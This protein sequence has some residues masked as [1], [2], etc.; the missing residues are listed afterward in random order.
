M[1][2]RESCVSSALG[3]GSCQVQRPR[4]SHDHGIGTAK[5]PGGP[6]VV[7]KGGG[8]VEEDRETS[9]LRL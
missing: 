5:R 6:S 1:M 3:R 7:R 2:T 8:E 4:G 9:R